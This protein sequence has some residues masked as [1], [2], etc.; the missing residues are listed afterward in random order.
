MLDAFTL[1]LLEEGSAFGATDP[2][3]IAQGPGRESGATAP[4]IE[5]SSKR[6]TPHEKDQKYRLWSQTGLT[7]KKTPPNFWPMAGNNNYRSAKPENSED[8]FRYLKEKHGI[9]TIVDLM[10]NKEGSN[11]RKA[12]LNYVSVPLSSKGPRPAGWN[13]IKNALMSGNTL[14]H[15]R[16]GADRTGAVVA[17]WEV[18]LGLKT[19]EEAY[20][21]TLQYGFKSPDHKGYPERCSKLP[22]TTPKEIAKKQ[23]CIDDSADPNKKLRKYILDTTPGKAQSTRARK[24]V[25]GDLVRLNGDMI[26]PFRKN[27]NVTLVVFYHGTTGQTPV[28][29]QIRGLPL[30]NIMFLI[31]NGSGKNYDEV[32]KTIDKLSNDYGITINNKKLGAWSAGSKGFST[33]AGEGFGVKMLADPSASDAIINSDLSGVYM[34]YNPEVWR[35]A[36]PGLAANLPVLAKKIEANGGQTKLMKGMGHTAILASILSQLV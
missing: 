23:E 6:L 30:D 5:S 19:P 16:H 34:E 25:E 9:T 13:K 21:D 3:A 12:G 35:T 4:T 11:V 32:K 20:K 26:Y 2:A 10:N 22:T 36:Y 7:S 17:R 14:V 1:S 18:E 28:L 27:A 24:A 29:Q 31:P 33:V 8:F 15:C